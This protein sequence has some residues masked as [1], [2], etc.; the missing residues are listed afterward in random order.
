M[1]CEL[2]KPLSWIANI[3]LSTG[4]HPD[5]LKTAKVVPSFKKGSKL[6]TSNYRPISLLSNI[7]KIFEKLVFSRVY[8]FFTSITLY[9]IYNMASD[10]NIPQTMPLLI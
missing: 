6:L 8:S 10:Q 7:N 3:C 9:M 4:T 2:S 5:E 1:R